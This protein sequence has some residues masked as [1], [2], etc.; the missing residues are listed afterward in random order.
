MDDEASAKTDTMIKMISLFTLVLLI[1][2]FT[3]NPV[4][5]GVEV[6]D[7]V[8]D[9]KAKAYNGGTWYDF[10]LYEQINTSWDGEDTNQ[11]WFVIEFMD[12]DCYY[13]WNSAADMS[14]LHSMITSPNWGRAQVELIVVALELNIEGHDSSREEIE[15]FRDKT[16]GDFKCNAGRDDCSTRGGEAHPF[17]YLDDLKSDTT[18]DWDIPGTPFYFIV[19]PDG[20]VAWS[21]G[22]AGNTDILDA[23]AGIVPVV[24]E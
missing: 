19:Q 13:C 15:A 24:Q 2:A 6:G 10:D 5:V 12:T 1:I 23:T 7:R 17:P 11:S 21:S 9:L 14:N 18:D 4:A 16:S 3:T 22:D 20:I 8:P